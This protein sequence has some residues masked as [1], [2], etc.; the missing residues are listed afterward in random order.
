[1]TSLFLCVFFP[2]FFVAETMSVSFECS[3][4]MFYTLSAQSMEVQWWHLCG[5]CEN[6]V[7]SEVMKN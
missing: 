2:L 7:Y 5:K 3:M 6:L 1:M 4:F